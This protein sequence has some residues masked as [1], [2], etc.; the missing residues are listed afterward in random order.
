V[1][2]T[3]YLARNLAHVIGRLWGWF[4]AAPGRFW[5]WARNPENNRLVWGYIVW[6]AM[7]VVVALPEL[8]SAIRDVGF[9]TISGTVGYLEYWHPEFALLVVG[10]LVWGA[11]HAIRVTAPELP[12]VPATAP[13]GEKVATPPATEGGLV[14]APGGRLSV[15]HEFQP[16]HPRFYIPLALALVAAAFAIV[17]LSRPDD[18]YLQGEVLYGSIALVWIA[19][20]AWLAYKHGRWV[21][22]ATLFRTIQDLESHLRTAAIVVAAGILILLVHLAF[23]P[24]PASIPDMQDLH[25]QFDKQRHEQKKEKEPPP[26]AL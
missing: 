4:R 5:R 23:Y 3:S 6:G 13:P 26:N 22:Y 8:L 19:I 16:L 9:P 2:L 7:G 1:D 12:R 10:L 14:R 11:F 17:R 25:K 18:R 24:W 20:P 15:A 21:P